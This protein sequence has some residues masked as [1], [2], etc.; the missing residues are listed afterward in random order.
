[1]R[2]VIE[3]FDISTGTGTI[4]ST[5]GTL[6]PFARAHLVRRSKEP[7][8]NARVAFRLKG[9]KV[10]KAIVAPTQDEQGSW[11]DLAFLPWDWLLY[12]P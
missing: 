2:G 8:T 6:Y 5:A 10:Y 3:S 11:W 9:D 4:Q 7:R 12:I 1:M